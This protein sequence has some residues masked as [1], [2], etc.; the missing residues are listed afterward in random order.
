[1]SGMGERIAPVS[2]RVEDEARTF[3]SSVY[4]WVCRSRRSTYIVHAY[5]HEGTGGCIH[6]VVPQLR[7][8]DGQLVTVGRAHRYT[9]RLCK[10][11]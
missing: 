4:A 3:E 10:H 6:S 11:P 2:G 9:E 7:G 1:M 8:A 5:Q